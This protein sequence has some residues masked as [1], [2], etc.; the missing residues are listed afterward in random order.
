MFAPIVLTVR[1]WAP[2][3]KFGIFRIMLTFATL[4]YPNY[5]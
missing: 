5:T 3:Y 1:A 2:E 4:K